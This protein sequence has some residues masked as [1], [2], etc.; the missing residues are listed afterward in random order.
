LETKEEEVMQR[1][2]KTAQAGCPCEGMVETES[3]REACS[4]A[5]T[6]TDRKDGAEDLLERLT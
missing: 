4:I 1:P 5:L 2:Q 6:E 3:N